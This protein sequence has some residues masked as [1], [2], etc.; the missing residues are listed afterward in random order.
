VT[1]LP[2]P[3]WGPLPGTYFVLIGAVSGASLVAWWIGYRYDERP[4]IEWALEWIA[5]GLLSVGAI[6]LVADLGRPMRFF[7]MLTQFSNL[8]SPMSVGA[9]V[10]GLEFFLLAVS[11]Y[12]LH[13]QRQ[14]GRAGKHRAGAG[15]TAWTF[16]TVRTALVLTSL[17]LAMYPVALLSRTWTSPLARSQGSAAIFLVTAVLMGV[18]LAQI[19]TVFVL[20]GSD[21]H[22]A[23]DLGRMTLGLICVEALLLALE[24]LALVGAGPAVAAAVDEL[25]HGDART[26]FWGLVV[27]IGLAVPIAGVL[28]SRNLRFVSSV[29]AVAAIVG[30]GTT[31]YLLFAAH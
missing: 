24:A 6:I 22:L 29:T 9:K 31:R 4:E 10:L 17:L 5:L 23:A 7:L 20:D 25:T 19:V 11:L 2:E 28:L 14:A 13:R 21:G 1:P 26:A 16:A 27:G 12:L 18:A 15:P 30:A 3:P 8:T